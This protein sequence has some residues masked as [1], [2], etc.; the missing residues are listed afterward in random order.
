MPR[1]D[2]VLVKQANQRLQKVQRN[3]N[4]PKQF[5]AKQLNC[6]KLFRQ[7][8]KRFTRLHSS[9]G[10]VA[11]LTF[12]LEIPFELTVLK[13]EVNTSQYAIANH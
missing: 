13:L 4:H 2:G 3:E 11:S 7:S 10:L 1:A 6:L 9:F 12:E 5:G 8:S